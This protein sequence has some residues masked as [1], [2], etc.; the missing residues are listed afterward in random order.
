MKR[1]DVLK[2]LDR[3][4]TLKQRNCVTCGCEQNTENTTVKR[5]NHNKKIMYFR[6]DCIVC[7]NHNKEKNSGKDM[8]KPSLRL[9]RKE[10]G[11]EDW[12]ND[13]GKPLI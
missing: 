7:C 4:Y 1:Q 2:A 11:C 5:A 10:L 8:D 12:Q 13:N 3:G 9:L 6:S